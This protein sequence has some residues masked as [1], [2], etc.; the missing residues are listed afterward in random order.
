MYEDHKGKQN[1][2]VSWQSP[3][4]SKRRLIEIAKVLG[5]KRLSKILENYAKDYK[6]WNHGMADLVLWSRDSE[7]G[8]ARIKFSEVKSETDRLS[9]QQIEWL[10]FMNRE[11][12]AAEVCLVNW[13]SEKSTEVFSKSLN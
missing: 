6:Y 5:G 13:P 2:F 10:K 11:G 4:L 7:T 1:G 12:I 9:D 3:K 8:E